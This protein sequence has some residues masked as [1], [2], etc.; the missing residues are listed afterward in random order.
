MDEFCRFLGSCPSK[1]SNG[2][3]MSRSHTTNSACVSVQPKTPTRLP[4]C[5]AS[6][7]LTSWVVRLS[8]L[9][10]T[11]ISSPSHFF[12]HPCCHLIPCPLASANAIRLSSRTTG[13]FTTPTTLSHPAKAKPPPL[14]VSTHKPTEL[15]L[16]SDSDTPVLGP[17]PK[18]PACLL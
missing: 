8:W 10:S 1:Q 2:I 13:T 3:T 17:T 4:P 15:T 16:L 12:L 6:M 9:S 18:R 7:N 14:L 11:S 5:S